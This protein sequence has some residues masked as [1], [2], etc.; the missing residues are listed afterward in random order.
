MAGDKL[1]QSMSI[2]SQTCCLKVSISWITFWK[3]AVRHKSFFNDIILRCLIIGW[4]LRWYGWQ[5]LKYFPS[6]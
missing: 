3:L 4:H 1:F 2:S 6:Y 5:H